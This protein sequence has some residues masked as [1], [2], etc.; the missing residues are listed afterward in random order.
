MATNGSIQSLAIDFEQRCEGAVPALYGSVRINS[1]ISAVPRISVANATALKGNFKTHAS[2]VILSLSIPSN[3]TIRVQYSTSNGTAIQG[4]DYLATSG[5]AQFPAGTTAQVVAIPIVGDRLARGSKTFHVV[6]SNSSGV[7]IAFAQDNVKILDPKIPLTVLSMYGQ[8][9]DYISPGFFLATI[10]DG[11][12]T[13]SR[14]YDNGVSAALNNGDAWELDFAAANNATLTPGTYFNAQRFPFQVSGTPGLSVYGAGRGCNTLT[15]QFVVNKANYSSTG[16]VEQLSADFQQH[17]EAGVP[18]LFG[19]LRIN[20]NFGQ[21]SVADA[22]IDSTSST[23]TFTVTLN[24]ASTT[25]VSVDFATADDTAVAGIDYA[26]TAQAITFSPG[27]VQQTVNVPL[28]TSNGGTKQFFG[29]LS[30]PTGARSGSTGEQPVSSGRFVTNRGHAKIPSS[31]GGKGALDKRTSAG[32]RPEPD[33]N[34]RAIAGA[35]RTEVFPAG[36]PLGLG[37]ERV[38]LTRSVLAFEPRTPVLSAAML[39]WLV[40]FVRTHELGLIY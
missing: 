3:Q 11:L 13:P 32:C 14:N 26:A 4:T 2:P 5:S 6:L 25:S 10:V 33:G 19:S 39:T 8:P 17:C 30:S 1:T 7:P 12:F 18:A 28:F 24:P 40:D 9:G 37:R 22:V 20:S 36:L 27:Q 35:W 16:A 34:S 38:L 21:M 31:A 23:A 29:Q 15:G